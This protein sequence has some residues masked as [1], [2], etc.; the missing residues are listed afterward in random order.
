MTSNPP[1]NAVQSLLQNSIT[2]HH[3]YP[4]FS[5]WQHA[6]IYIVISDPGSAGGF[7]GGWN[8][9]GTYRYPFPIFTGNM[10]MVWVGTHM[11][12]D[13]HIVKDW[14]TMTLS[15]EIA[16]TISDPDSHGI[17]VKP[18]NALPA[19]LRNGTQIG[20]N[21]PED[22]NTHYGY[23]LGGDLVQPY[24][25]VRDGA[26]IV[27]DGNVQK[28]YLYPIWNDATLNQSNPGASFTATFN[29]NDPAVIADPYRTYA[30]LRDEAPVAHLRDLDLWVLSRYEDVL[31]ARQPVNG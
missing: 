13:G 31:A 3:V 11:G 19:S 9:P 18:P 17:Q 28:F 21:E 22:G 14:F 24:W 26:Y 23:R 25:S 27:P 16:E 10:R 12:N 29:L 20:D 7:S 2:N 6:P 30:R 8:A 5:N 4:G 15:H 1:A